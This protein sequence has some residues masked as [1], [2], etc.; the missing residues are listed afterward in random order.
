MGIKE[1]TKK[2]VCILGAGAAGLCAARH[3][4]D[5]GYD[6]TVFEQQKCLGGTWLYSP[7]V[8][9]FSSLYEKMHTNLPKQIMGF[10]HLPF[11]TD[12][13]ESFVR[14]QE[15]LA[16]LKRYAKSIYEFIHVS[17][18]LKRKGNIY[19]VLKTFSLFW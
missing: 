4:L 15:V 14:H 7:E 3:C 10:E 16:Y 5:E 13:P 1:T 9:A 11:E 19:S 12:G 8:N 6:L 17:F 18:V 2:R